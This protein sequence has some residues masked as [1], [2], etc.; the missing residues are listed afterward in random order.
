MNDLFVRDCNKPMK[1]EIVDKLERFQFKLGSAAQQSEC[2]I[3]ICD[4]EDAETLVT[5]P[6]K[7][8]F[9]ENCVQGW[10]EKMNWCPM[11]RDPTAE[12]L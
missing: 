1:K 8:Y 9:H 4:F 2:S 11:C 3:C 5:L 12:K 10:F 7:H 6:C